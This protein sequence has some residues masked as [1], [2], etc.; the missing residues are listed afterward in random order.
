VP[1]AS[2]GLGGTLRV[3]YGS[4]AVAANVEDGDIFE[5]CRLPAGAVV[6]GGAFY[7]GD[8]DTGTEAVDIDLGW[9][10]N[11]VEAADPDGFVNAGVL[12]GDAITD[13]LAAGSNYR[14]FPMTSGVQSFSAE[15]VVQAEANVAAAT[16]AAGTITAVIYYIL[17]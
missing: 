10:A 1:V 2:H 3:A 8:L 9:A 5:L 13:L 12:S 14:P 17:N 15:T 4:Y 11:G 7:A 16:F 6:V